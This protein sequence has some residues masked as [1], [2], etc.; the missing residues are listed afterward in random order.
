MVAIAIAELLHLLNAR[1]TMPWLEGAL[2]DDEANKARIY[3]FI[4]C[5]TK[6]LATASRKGYKS[7][8]NINPLAT[9]S[10]YPDGGIIRCSYEDFSIMMESPKWEKEDKDVYFGIY[11]DLDWKL[12]TECASFKCS[13]PGTSERNKFIFTQSCLKKVDRFVAMTGTEAD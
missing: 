9:K 5:P 3:T 1:M 11:D 6:Y 12:R 4:V 2:T 13:N 10:D 7:E 8:H